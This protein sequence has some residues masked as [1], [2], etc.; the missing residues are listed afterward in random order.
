[1]N[2]YRGYGTYKQWNITQRKKNKVMLIAG[3]WV[4]PEII[5]LTQTEKDK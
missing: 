3:T 4:D 1:M 5:T 2:G